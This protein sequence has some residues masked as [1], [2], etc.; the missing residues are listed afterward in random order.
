MSIL[1]ENLKL[2][3]SQEKD[4]TQEKIGE[5]LF[6]SRERY[7]KYESGTSEPPLEIMLRIGQYFHVSIDVLISVDLR[8]VP[9][10]ELL[11]LAGN[12][13]LLPITVNKAGDDFIEIVPYKA[14]AGYLTG[15]SD[16]TY[17]EDL[18][19]ISVPFLTGGKYRGFPVEGDSMPP[20]NDK[21]VIIG[22]FIEDFVLRKGR[23]Y[24]IL[25]RSEGIVY[26]RLL[27]VGSKSITV[28]SDNTFYPPYEIKRSEILEVWEFAIGFSMDDSQNIPVGGIPEMFSN[29]MSGIGNIKEMISNPGRK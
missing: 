10:D 12:R 9:M 8:K 7:A 16:P 25:S 4:L 23:T 22:K 18:Q 13:I 3:R 26:K 19:R 20:Y 2:L 21:S 11:K 15:Y 28:A 5:V 1:S 24:V 29:I 6:I 27:K 17:I 14:K